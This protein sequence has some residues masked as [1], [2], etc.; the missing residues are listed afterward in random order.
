MYFCT[1]VLKVEFHESK[2]PFLFLC[3]L[4]SQVADHKTV[5]AF[6]P[7]VMAIDWHPMAHLRAYSQLRV[8]LPGYSKH[9]QLF[10]SRSGKE[11]D[12]IGVYLA[13]AWKA[14]GSPGAPTLRD[15]HTAISTLVHSI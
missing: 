10:F 1:E 2:V 11:M 6:G 3:F 15:V 8:S 5:Q 4:L 14:C 12:K 9:P 13:G 7:A